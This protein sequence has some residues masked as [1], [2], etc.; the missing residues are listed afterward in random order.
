MQSASKRAGLGPG[1]DPI[2]VAVS[3]GADSTCLLD[4][5]HRLGLPLVVAH[6]DHGLRPGSWAEARKVLRLAAK[7]QLPAIAAR[8]HG[9]KAEGGSL[10]D[11]ARVA[12]YRFLGDCARTRRS[13]VLAVGHT[14]DD[15]AETVLLHLLRGAGAAGLRGMRLE[16]TLDRITGQPADAG[17]RVVRPLLGVPRTATAAWCR[18]QRLPT[19]HD[20]TND[21]PAILRNRIRA[22]LLPL[23]ATYNTAIRDVLARMADVLSA[24][25]DAVEAV[26]EAF[27][28]AVVRTLGDGRLGVEPQEMAALP[29]GLQRV[30][31]RWILR[32]LAAERSEVGFE[33]VER[34]RQALGAS[35]RISLAGALEVSTEG[36]L[37]VFGAPGVPGSD[38]GYP[39]VPGLKPVRF[40]A[41]LRLALNPG[42]FIQAS[43]EERPPGDMAPEADPAHEIQLDA[44]ALGQ[45]FELSTALRGE[46]MTPFGGAGSK[47]VRDL[48]Q[49]ARIPV[50]ARDA[51]PVIRQGGAIVWLVGIRRAEGARISEH[52]RG[53]VRM[54]LAAPPQA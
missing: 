34:A 40:R 52:T 53:V 46:R 31:L 4:C 36:G 50:S 22:E 15:Q 9:L 51:W 54:R 2:L 8:A 1:D 33:S 14:Q 47:K 45:D 10:E 27:A 29:L 6:F 7:L 24:E 30:V 11:A 43:L 37:R 23:M 13:R 19:V 21:D 39:Q 32:R 3:G 38:A 5:L 41:P 20:P 42:W 17:I 18:E 26:A 49:Q 25:A 16:T 12:R 28:P 44:D 35:E 48:L